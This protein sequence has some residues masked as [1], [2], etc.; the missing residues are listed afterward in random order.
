MTDHSFT[1]VSDGNVKAS[2]DALF[3]AGCDDATFGT[4]DG[5]HYADFDREARTFADAVASAIA[6]V[7]GAD[8]PDYLAWEASRL[9]ATDK[10]VHLHRRSGALLP[11]RRWR[12]SSLLR[13]W[14]RRLASRSFSDGYARRS[15][16]T[17]GM[18]RLV[19]C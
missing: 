11:W 3:E 19:F 13:R 7:V 5:V 6:T 9:G 17:T 15:R 16:I 2:L 18:R 12:S 8:K 1:L 14:S 10:R 4:V